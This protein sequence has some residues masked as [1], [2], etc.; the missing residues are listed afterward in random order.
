MK[1]VLCGKIIFGW[2]NN[3]SPLATKGE[4][5]EMCNTTLVI[6]ARI[7]MMFRRRDDESRNQAN[8]S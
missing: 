3:P 5:C 7:D 2:G 8:P 4:C 1:C 6:P